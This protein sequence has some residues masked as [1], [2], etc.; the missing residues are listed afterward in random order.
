M[1][2]SKTTRQSQRTTTS[3]ND[4]SKTATFFKTKEKIRKIREGTADEKIFRMNRI[5]KTNLQKMLNVTMIASIVAIATTISQTIF[6]NVAAAASSKDYRQ[7][8][9]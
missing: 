9:R 4:S 6:S 8:K 5:I 2:N 3:S 1:I 7:Q